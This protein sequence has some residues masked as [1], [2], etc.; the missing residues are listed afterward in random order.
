[1]QTKDEIVEKY[2]T[3]LNENIKL[4]RKLAHWRNEA[5]YHIDQGRWRG[6]QIHA[7]RQRH[8][9]KLWL[10]TR[11]WWGRLFDRFAYRAPLQT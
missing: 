2:S 8:R 3:A 6:R 1:L 5:E 10:G 11:P 4:R 9:Y 7:E